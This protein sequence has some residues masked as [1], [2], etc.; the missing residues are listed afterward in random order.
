M[1]NEEILELLQSTDREERKRAVLILA[2]YGDESAVPHLA[3][4][5][6]DEDKEIR[7]LAEMALWKIWCRSGDREVDRILTEGIALMNAGTYEK[8]V[9][10]FNEVISMRPDFAEGY[11]KRATTFY[12]MGEYTKS[13]EDCERT[14]AINPFHFGALSGEGLCHFALRDLGQALKY[15]ERALAINPNMDGIRQ[16]IQRVR[17]VIAAQYN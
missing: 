14:L 15:F 13:I 6:R 17:R 10:K 5:L 12:L 7:F 3:Q 4:T 2:E 11:N 8:A 1:D 16:N 9:E